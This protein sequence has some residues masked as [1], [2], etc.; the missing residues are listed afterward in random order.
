MPLVFVHGVNNRKEDPG[1]KA[2]VLVTTKFLDRH[3]KG[4]IVNGKT[5]SSVAP[6]FPYWGDLATRFAWN[7]ASLPTDDINAL[8][9]GVPDDMRPLVVVIGEE[10]GGQAQA[11][12]QPLLTLARKSLP[13]AVAALSE[14]LIRAATDAD[15]PRVATFVTTA[16][17]YAEA[18]QAPPWLAGLSTD[19]QFVNELIKQATPKA[20]E[21]VEALGA[22]DFIV[23]P[24]NAA[25]AKIKSAISGAA[26][27]VLDKAGDFAS[28]KILAWTRRPL[29]AVIGR[30][31]GDV[32][33]YLDA[34]GNQAAPGPIPQRLIADI[35]QALAEASPGEPLV[36]MGHSLGGVILFD[37]LSHFRPDL[38][39]DLLITVGSQVSHF[40]EIKRFK[41]SDNSIPSAAQPLAKRPANIAHWINVFD[42]VDI[43]AYACSH[44]FEGVDDFR[45]DTQT[46]TVK[47]HGAYFEQHRFFARLRARMEGPLK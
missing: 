5:L 26:G 8:G 32:F 46:Y 40:E 13:K 2:G 30:F 20:G 12:Q 19:A 39:V 9:A 41:T 29:N 34:R 45:Y 37:L 24:L 38:Q 27:S 4:A 31:F 15:A 47:A 10:I 22:F 33:V 28:T 35:D 7:M 14:V 17:A 16:Q 11:K 25:A 18:N 43:F 6:R 3:F 21:A 36:L 1:Y 23:G 44:V 42:D